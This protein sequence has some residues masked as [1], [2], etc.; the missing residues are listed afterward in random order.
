MSTIAFYPDSVVKAEN[1]YLD[2]RR[3]V[4][5]IAE[6]LASPQTTTPLTVGIFGQWGCASTW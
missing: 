5:P 3:F 6:V 1:D 2:F 4:N